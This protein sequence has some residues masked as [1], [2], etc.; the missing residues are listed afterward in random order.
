MKQA[1]FQNVNYNVNVKTSLIT[2]SLD[3]YSRVQSSYMQIEIV[4][5]S[6]S[7]SVISLRY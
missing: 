5:V 3:L 4:K 2:L 1:N 7:S 6:G